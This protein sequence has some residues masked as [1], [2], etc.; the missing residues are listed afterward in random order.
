LVIR[1]TLTVR[2]V[3]AAQDS[4]RTHGIVNSYWQTR[5]FTLTAG[6]GEQ[7]LR[8]RSEGDSVSIGDTLAVRTSSPETYDLLEAL[9]AD[10]RR[11]SEEMSAQRSSHNERL[12]DLLEKT[13]R[14]SQDLRLAAK[15]HAAGFSSSVPI[16][17][18]KAAMA[19]RTYQRD[20]L[21]AS[22][23]RNLDRLQARMARIDERI[24]QLQIADSVSQAALLS[25][26]KGAIRSVRLLEQGGG[27][28]AVF[29][30]GV[31]DP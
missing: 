24:T 30:I 6:K 26:V 1:G 8:V 17:A 28:Q 13:R 14:D 22:F 12:G 27:S 9:Q 16:E 3:V 20:Q 19:Q 25:P 23:R 7:I 5:A 4:S 29:S 2:Q 21:E 18:K 15:L 11:L 10:L 31:S